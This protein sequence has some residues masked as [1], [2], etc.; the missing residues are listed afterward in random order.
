MYS[1][2]HDKEA[3]RERSQYKSNQMTIKVPFEGKWR[4]FPC[5]AHAKNAAGENSRIKSDEVG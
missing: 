3:T 2:R 4:P 5:R 1:A